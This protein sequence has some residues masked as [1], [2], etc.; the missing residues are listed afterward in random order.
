M[1]RH[2]RPERPEYCGYDDYDHDNAKNGN[3]YLRPGSWECNFCGAKE[4]A[5]ENNI[6][7]YGHRAIG[8]GPH[9]C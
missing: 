8:T 4:T 5:N 1:E 7:I 9:I 6:T 3:G 2:E